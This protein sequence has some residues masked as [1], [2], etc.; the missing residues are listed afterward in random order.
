M[1]R[2]RAVYYA[3]ARPALTS[4]RDLGRKATRF[5]L[6]LLRVHFF[7]FAFAPSTPSRRSP[8]RS[9]RTC[10]FHLPRHDTMPPKPAAS[11]EK[12]YVP[13]LPSCNGFARPP[14]SPPLP[15]F[16]RSETRASERAPPRAENNLSFRLSS[17]SRRK[18]APRRKEQRRGRRTRDGMGRGGSSRKP[19]RM[20]ALTRRRIGKPARRGERREPPHE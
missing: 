1:C 6:S 7:I 20:P 5:P 10:L 9:G 19:I 16:S 14:P 4:K 18:K 12:K 13:G 15:P 2:A 17:C 3:T 8:D 11:H